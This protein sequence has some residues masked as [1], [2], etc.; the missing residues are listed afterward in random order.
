MIKIILLLSLSAFFYLYLKKTF[1][2]KIAESNYRRLNFKR[3]YEELLKITP[4]LKEANLKLEKTAQETIALYDITKEICNTL[5]E[6]TIFKSLKERINKYVPVDDCKFVKNEADLNKPQGYSVFSLNLHKKVIGYLSVSGLSIEDQDKFHI[7]GH[8]FL[9]GIKRA[10]LY[11]RVQELTITDTLTDIFNRRY[12]LERFNEELKRSRNFNYRFSLLMC[13]ID[14]FKAFNDHYGHLVGDAILKEVSRIIKGAIRQVDFIGR[15]GGEE[16]AIVF[17]ETD[18]I[19]ASLAAE[20]IRQ[21][22]ES[23][24]IRIYDEELKITTSIGIAS[25]PD[26]ASD[27]STLIDKA[28]QALYLAKEKGRNR[29]CVYQPKDNS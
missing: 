16:L 13:D 3:E 20:R 26:D 24:K 27:A 7:L 1:D 22:M 28:D 11:Q 21:N 15:Y 18:K 17:V 10:F 12:F 9:L 19:Q 2:K 6:D 25:F 8:Q 23:R 29:V 14:H 5:D 4:G